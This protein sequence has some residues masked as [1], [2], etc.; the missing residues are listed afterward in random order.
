MYFLHSG[1]VSLVRESGGARRTIA[2]L[3]PGDHFGE[4]A[5]IDG[6]PRLTTAVSQ[7]DSLLLV[8]D[9]SGFEST[10]RDYPD[11]AFNIF[12]QLTERVRDAER[13]LHSALERTSERRS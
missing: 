7:T 2:E 6:S 9:R 5:I 10:I 4:M 1:L 11:V 8:L 13:R 3:E 12:R